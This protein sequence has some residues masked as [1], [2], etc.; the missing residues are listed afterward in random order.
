MPPPFCAKALIEDE[1]SKASVKTTDH[2]SL[3]NEKS[4]SFFSVIYLMR[5]FSCP[6][7]CEL[8]RSDR[9]GLLTRGEEQG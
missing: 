7:Q 1:E 4:F 6:S 5:S 3:A 8:E 9:I 2:A